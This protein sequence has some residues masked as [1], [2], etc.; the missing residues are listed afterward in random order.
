M[1]PM[2]NIAMATAIA[3]KDFRSKTFKSRVRIDRSIQE[4]GLKC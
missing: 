3:A 1:A 4:N 2:L